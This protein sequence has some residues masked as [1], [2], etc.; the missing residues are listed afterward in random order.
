MKKMFKLIVYLVILRFVIKLFNE[1]SFVKEQIDKLK[2]EITNLETK[3]LEI[4]IKEFFKKY[5]LNNKDQQENQE[6]I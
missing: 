4:K 5:D 6:D 1:N 3:D 2:E